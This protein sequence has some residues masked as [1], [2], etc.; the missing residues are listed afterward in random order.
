M[1]YPHMFLHIM[2]RWVE[3]SGLIALLGGLSYYYFIWM[4][5]RQRMGRRNGMVALIV[6]VLCVLTVS[7]SVDLVLRALMMSGA[8][9]WPRPSGDFPR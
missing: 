7:G 5:L 4:P 6:T 8:T 2:V 3:L 9:F 1:T